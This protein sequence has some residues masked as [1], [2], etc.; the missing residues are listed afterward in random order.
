[1]TA[2][3]HFLNLHS[4]QSIFSE[5]QNSLNFYLQPKHHHS[6]RLLYFKAA[7]TSREKLCS[8]Y[9]F[10]HFMICHFTKAYIKKNYFNTYTGASLVAQWLRVPPANAGDTGSSTDPGRSHM[11]QSI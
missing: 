10:L 6:T 8:M 5:W 1:M 4:Y 3:L 2:N 9:T 11:L 7:V